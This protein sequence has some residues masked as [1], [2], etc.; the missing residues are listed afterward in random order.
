VPLAVASALTHGSWF[1]RGL[2][3]WSALALGVPT[4]WVGILLILLFAVELRLLPAASAF[5]P[6]WESPWQMLRNTILPAATLGLYVS[7][8]FARFLR[9]S[10]IGAPRVCAN[11]RSWCGTSCAMRCCP[12]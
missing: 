12:S 1:D 6:F 11:P 5:V 4:F 10:L 7:G 2:S 3:G 8:I 9:G